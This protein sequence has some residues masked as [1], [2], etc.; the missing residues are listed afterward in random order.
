MVLALVLGDMAESALRQSLIMSQGAPMIFFASPIAALLV[1][2]SIWL[3]AASVV[4]SLVRK[5][6]DHSRH[7]TP[8]AQASR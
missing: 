5:A 1:S 3:L 7:R 6:W 4:H 2:L 8:S